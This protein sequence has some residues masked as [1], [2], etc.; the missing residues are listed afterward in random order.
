MGNLCSHDG[1]RVVNREI[2]GHGGDLNIRNDDARKV[3]MVISYD[4]EPKFYD[5]EP[6][7]GLLAPLS[8]STDGKNFATLAKAAGAEVHEWCD[9]PERANKEGI[10]FHGFPSKPDILAS[11]QQFLAD[12]DEN[13]TFIFFYSGHGKQSDDNENV[14]EVTATELCM[15]DKSGE[16]NPMKDSEIQEALMNANPDTKILF[17]TDCCQCGSVCNLD[18]PDFEDR[19]I[20]H[21][22]A[23]KD[24]QYAL[25]WGAGG[26][27]T[28]CLVE[29]IEDIV[30]NAD[31]DDA[32][33]FSMTSL[34]NAAYAKFK[35]AAEEFGDDAGEQKFC[36]EKNSE[37]DPDTFAWPLVPPE[38]WKEQTLLDTAGVE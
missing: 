7:G 24:S 36:F 17:V 32:Q 22:A 33:Q 38:G 26:G 21:I 1:P 35:R 27:L 4:Y 25:D 3:C 13:D 9:N 18:D 34:F 14:D 19:P 31:A 12:L 2:G 28:T 20:C 5:A 10:T 30:E 23:V 37:F 6:H 29:A 11:M 16:Y 15:C 8:G